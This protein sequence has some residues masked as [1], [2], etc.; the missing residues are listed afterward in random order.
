MC[1]WIIYISFAAWPFLCCYVC[2]RRYSITLGA[3]LAPDN[4]I[5]LCTNVLTLALTVRSGT[6]IYLP[7]TVETS[8]THD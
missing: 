8:V 1:L 5:V 4:S 6:V 3:G 2:Y 7:H